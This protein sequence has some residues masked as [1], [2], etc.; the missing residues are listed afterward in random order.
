MVRPRIEISEDVTR[1]LLQ[2]A[3]KEFRFSV[4]ELTQ[5]TRGSKHLSQARKATYAAAFLAS[6]STPWAAL[7][8]ALRRDRTTVREGAYTA[9]SQA[10]VDSRLDLSIRRVAEAARGGA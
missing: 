1:R 10:K 2:A 9:L 7:G 6:P 4:G 8:R 5:S 3:S